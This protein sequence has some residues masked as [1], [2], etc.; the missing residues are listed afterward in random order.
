MDWSGWEA[1][2]SGERDSRMSA[3]GWLPISAKVL[4]VFSLLGHPRK[5]NSVTNK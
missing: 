2:S 5:V 4:H 1:R 3:F